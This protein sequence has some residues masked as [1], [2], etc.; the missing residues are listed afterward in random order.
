MPLVKLQARNE[1][2]PPLDPLN[3]TRK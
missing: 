3:E 1:T 2:A